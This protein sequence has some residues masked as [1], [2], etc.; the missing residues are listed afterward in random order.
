[1]IEAGHLKVPA[2]LIHHTLIDVIG[3]AEGW[4]DWLKAAGMSFQRKTTMLGVDTTNMAFAM[5]RP[6]F[7]VTLTRR[8]LAQDRLENG[9][10]AQPFACEVSAKENV[11]LT[12]P[13]TTPI[14]PDAAAFKCWIVG[15][16]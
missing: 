12:L 9:Q 7:G 2:D 11:Y 13:N 5:L 15:H 4:S 14:H 1:M 6:D 8:S 10:L 16:A 3:Y